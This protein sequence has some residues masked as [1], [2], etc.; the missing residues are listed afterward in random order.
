MERKFILSESQLNE[1]YDQASC[2][3]VELLTL[4][5]MAQEVGNSCTGKRAID[6]VIGLG[7][8]LERLGNA[9]D[10]VLNGFDQNGGVLREQG[11]RRG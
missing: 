4:A 10:P 11:V 2:V 7:F 3:Q 8:L 9:L 1:L 6:V 5:E